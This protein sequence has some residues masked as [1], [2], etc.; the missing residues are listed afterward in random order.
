MPPFFYFSGMTGKEHTWNFPSHE[1]R[2]SGVNRRSQEIV[3]ERVGEGRL[4]IAKRTRDESDD[5]I[6]YCSGRKLTSG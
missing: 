6:G 3:L 5:R 2:R 1:F 4:L